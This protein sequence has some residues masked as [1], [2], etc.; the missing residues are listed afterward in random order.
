ML[1]FIHRLISMD[2]SEAKRRERAARFAG[3]T[4]PKA[5]PPV[6]KRVMAHP[7]GKITIKK[8]GPAVKFLKRIIASGKPLSDA[9][10]KAAAEYGLLAGTTH[11][12][13]AP[14]AQSA[15][16]TSQRGTPA[17][18]PLQARDP[19]A[20]QPRVANKKA[21]QRV[22]GHV[23][24]ETGLCAAFQAGCAVAQPTPKLGNTPDGR[25]GAGASVGSQTGAAVTLS[26]AQ[27]KRRRKRKQKSAAEVA[28]EKIRAQRCT[29][30]GPQ[31]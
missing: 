20:R 28:A 31:A 7:G 23:D 15:P 4:G 6:P 2:R 14:S 12:V 22:A 17:T 21:T 27:K 30:T 5:A 16:R 1:L 8:H 9:Q 18:E 29:T 25:G 10:K 3:K 11:P 24:G 19:Q 26:K 13:A